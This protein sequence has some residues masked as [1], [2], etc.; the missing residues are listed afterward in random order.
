MRSVRITSLGD[1]AL[2]VNVCDGFEDDAERCLKAVMDAHRRLATAQLPGV[3]EITP[4]FTTLGIFIDSIGEEDAEVKIAAAL[5]AD[6]SAKQ[7]EP[8]KPRPTEIP[9][10]Y[11][12]EFALDLPE[13]AEQ[14]SL[15]PSE[16][17][18]RHAAARYRVR[19]LGF[20]PGF[21]YLSGLPAELATARRASPRTAIAAGSVGIGGRQTGIYPQQSPGGWNIIGRTPLRLFDPTSTPPSLFAIGDEVRFRPITRAE[22]HQLSR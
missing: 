10:C 17:I 6:C 21:P 12:E 14:S 3:I 20:T 16:V 2:V 9:V 19:C 1:S 22:F 5:R 4:A 15:P 8:L 13:V 11:D 7:N 18:K